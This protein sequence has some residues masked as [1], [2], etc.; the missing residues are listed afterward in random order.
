M[1]FL[2]CRENDQDSIDL[3]DVFCQRILSAA[4]MLPYSEVRDPLYEGDGEVSTPDHTTN[5]EP[6]AS[7]DTTKH[8]SN[9]PIYLIFYVI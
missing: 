8:S 7:I 1:S 2:A 6:E 5:S 4:E 3:E 9:N